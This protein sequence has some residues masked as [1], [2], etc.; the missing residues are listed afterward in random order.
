MIKCVSILGTKGSQIILLQALEHMRRQTSQQLSN[1][2]QDEKFADV[3]WKMLIEYLP[4]KLLEELDKEQNTTIR[5]DLS[6][7]SNLNFS[8]QI[9]EIS[10][11][12]TTT[13]EGN[14]KRVPTVYQL[15]SIPS[16][17]ALRAKPSLEEPSILSVVNLNNMS[18]EDRDNIRQ[19]IIT[20]FLTARSIDYE[21]QW[22]LGMIRRRTLDILIKSVEQAK[23]KYSIT[24]HWKLIVKYFRLS[25]LLIEILKFER[26]EI[27][28]QWKNKLLFDHIFLT[29]ELAL[30]ES[31]AWRNN[32][33]LTDF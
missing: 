7:H 4:D 12:Q 9:Q 3:D 25:I 18:D 13:T 33:N 16:S 20:R 11:A 31:F 8:L 22:Y 32:C 10:R 27:I 19:E 29:I 24:I 14:F 1:M 30:S 23:Q 15:E 26:F 2:K 28:N 21:K 17:S 5:R 6:C